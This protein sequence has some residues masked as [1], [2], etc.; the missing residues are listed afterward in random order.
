MAAP[1]AQVVI[2]RP[3]A[4]QNVINVG[5]GAPAR[6]ICL[7]GLEFTGGSQG[8]KLVDC[9]NVWINQC[10][11][12]D[13][14]DAGISANSSNTSHLYLTRNQIWN[15][16]T[17]GGTS[18]AL[19]L[20]A[21]AGLYVMSQSVIALNTVY[22]TTSSPA[23][24]IGIEV[25]QG[26]WGNEIAANLVHDCT[27]PCLLVYGTAGM[28]P[29]VVENNRCFR[30]G[31]F[32]MQVQSECIV[33]NNLVISGA[34]S[35]FASQATVQGSPT[36]LS[37]VHN[38]FVNAGGAVRLSAW[39]SGTNM[40]FANNACYS[41]TAQAL[42]A[43]TSTVGVTYAGNVAYGTVTSGVGGIQS[44]T[45]LGDLVNLS[46]DATLN[47]ARPSLASPLRAAA[48]AAY[49][50]ATDIDFYPRS[51]PNTTGCYGP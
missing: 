25:K 47:D 17:A 7:Q 29:N 30:S 22:G 36:E 34:G 9:A 5:A 6:Y 35:C 49:A 37:I 31:D 13:T 8:I 42:S 28:P 15:P 50:T 33:R 24:G 40:V 12:H 14:G 27:R 1:G 19:Y 41:Q 48:V 18:D 46:W 43:T 16:D 23:P 2:T 10:L 32:T 39:E 11:I 51:A 45:G 4:N 21:N 38:T 44:G 20:G 3:D 26:S